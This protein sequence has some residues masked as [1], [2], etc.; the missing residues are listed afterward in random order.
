MNM[1]EILENMGYTKDQLNSMM[2]NEFLEIKHGKELDS[3][4]LKFIKTKLEND[5][6]FVGANK[7]ILDGFGKYVN[8]ND[9]FEL[10]YINENVKSYFALIKRPIVSNIFK[11]NINNLKNVS[12]IDFHDTDKVKC[13][14]LDNLNDSIIYFIGMLNFWYGCLFSIKRIGEGEKNV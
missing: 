12:F 13:L 7:E 9:L 11:L 10:Y 4:D 8:N 2:K 6:I 3:D 5:F 1:I 14:E